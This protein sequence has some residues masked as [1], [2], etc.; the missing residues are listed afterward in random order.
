[1]PILEH[2][3]VCVLPADPG[4][5]CVAITQ[6]TQ[7]IKLQIKA[8]V[9]QACL[10]R[11]KGERMKAYK[12]RAGIQHEATGTFQQDQK[13]AAYAEREA[14]RLSNWRRTHFDRIRHI[15]PERDH[16]TRTLPLKVELC[17]GFTHL[18][19]II[20]VFSSPFWSLTVHLS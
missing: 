20:A 12:T 14:H 10:N 11:L 9:G 4:S 3:A 18:R 5:D 7:N 13:R 6:L 1:M 19:G 8:S 16:L 2:W 15:M 17:G